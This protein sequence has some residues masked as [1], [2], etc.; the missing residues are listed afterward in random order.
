MKK[1]LVGEKSKLYISITV[2]LKLKLE[3]KTS[4][5]RKT[6]NQVVLCIFTDPEFLYSP[7]ELLSVLG[8]FEIAR[9]VASERFFASNEANCKL[10]KIQR[11]YFPPSNQSR[12]CVSSM[13]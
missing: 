12:R 10:I 8:S 11:Q 6:E 3:K 13:M 4:Q 2:Q 7:L 5:E 1:K 9:S